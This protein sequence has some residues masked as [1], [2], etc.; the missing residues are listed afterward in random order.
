MA[1]SVRN[2]PDERRYAIYVDGELAGS[3]EY[4]I[5][6]DE[7]VFIHTEVDQTRQERGLATELVRAALDDV[8]ASTSYRL[9]AQCPFV[10]AF[11]EKNP[12]YADLTGRGGSQE[13]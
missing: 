10:S 9:V 2:E 3:S 1:R 8:R 5:R 12:E 11:V 6:D 4:R 7:I 13:R